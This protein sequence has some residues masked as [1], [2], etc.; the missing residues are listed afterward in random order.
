M[1][2]PSAHRL[3]WVTPCGLGSD[4]PGRSP[5]FAD[6]RARD[7]RPPAD[8]EESRSLDSGIRLECNCG[9]DSGGPPYESRSCL[10]HTS[11]ILKRP[12]A[13]L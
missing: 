4:Q 9:A 10:W 1:C 3:R 8:G 13:L 5:N 7:P 11:S 6:N 12:R 2:D